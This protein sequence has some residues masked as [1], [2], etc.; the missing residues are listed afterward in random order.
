MVVA[1]GQYVYV[2]LQIVQQIYG[3]SISS[4]GTLTA[5]NGFPIPLSAIG[6]I[7]AD[8]FAQN[9]VITNPAGTLLFISSATDE[10]IAVYQIG[11]DGSLTAANAEEVNIP[12][13]TK[14]AARIRLALS[15]IHLQVG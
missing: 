13:A 3:F 4:T 11:S 15:M 9:S 2:V 12:P 8:G 5:L 10:Q 14:A 7:P 1:Q 6:G